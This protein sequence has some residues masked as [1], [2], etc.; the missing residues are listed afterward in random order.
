V[1]A[2]RFTGKTESITD[3]IV[4]VEYRGE[5]TMAEIK[6]KAVLKTGFLFCLRCGLRKPKDNGSKYCPNCGIKM[7]EEGPLPYVSKSTMNK[8]NTDENGTKEGKIMDRSNSIFGQ[9]QQNQFNK[10]KKDFSRVS[11]ILKADNSDYENAIN[12]FTEI[13]SLNPDDA[14]SYFARATLKVRLGDIEGARLDFKMS[15]MCHRTSNFGFENY[16]L[17]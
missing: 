7:I 9:L 12:E 11:A 16:P 1:E 4:S 15:E 13:I 3:F 8:K 17:V 5:E 2:A 10:N 14:N 6:F